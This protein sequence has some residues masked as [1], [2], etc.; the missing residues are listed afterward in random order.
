MFGYVR[1]LILFL[2]RSSLIA[3]SSLVFFPLILAITS[4]RFLLEKTSRVRRII[5]RALEGTPACNGS[6]REND[7]DV[8][9]GFASNIRM[10]RLPA[11][12]GTV[13]KISAGDTLARFVG[14]SRFSR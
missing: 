2:I 10:D 1:N 8:N 7:A 13:P 4:L 14:K 6:L 9:V 11:V 5:S 3:R 12:E